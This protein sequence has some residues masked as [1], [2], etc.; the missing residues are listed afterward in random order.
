MF[1]L[2]SPLEALVR[3]P[4][5]TS[6]A[7]AECGG[8]PETKSRAILTQDKRNYVITN[9]LPAL[10]AL[11]QSRINKLGSKRI[12]L[13]LTKVISKPVNNG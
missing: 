9:S 5:L 12:K 13:M 1:S 8:I 11:E 7:L 10:S 2:R 3:I 6:I 4:L